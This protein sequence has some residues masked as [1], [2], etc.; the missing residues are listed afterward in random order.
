M[1]S[2][3]SLELSAEKGVGNGEWVTIVTARGEIECRAL[4]TA[5]MRPLRARGRM[6][7]TIGL[8]YHWSYVGRITGDT[9]NELIPFVADP[10]VSIQESKA[11]TGDLRPGRQSLGRRAA[12]GP[13]TAP[14]LNAGPPRDG[15]SVQSPARLPSQEPRR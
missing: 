1:F 5:R 13:V 12:T 14:A 7:H 9:T 4:V 10:N 15:P 11:F 6:I 2:E 3:I 8:P